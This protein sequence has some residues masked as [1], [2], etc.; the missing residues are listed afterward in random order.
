MQALHPPVVATR[1][2]GRI[3]EHVGID[4]AVPIDA[5]VVRVLPAVVAPPGEPKRAVALPHA[6]GQEDH[7][8]QAIAEGRERQRR[9]PGVAHQAETAGRVASQGH[10]GV[11]V[12]LVVRQAPGL[13]VAPEHH[14]VP[15][16]LARVG[17]APQRR[18]RQCLPGLDLL[19]G[20]A[21][22]LID[23]R[24][25]D[26]GNPRPRGPHPD[27]LRPRP[28][29]TDV[30]DHLDRPGLPPAAVVLPVA[31][32]VIGTRGRDEHLR[33]GLR[34]G[35]RGTGRHPRVGRGLLEIRQDVDDPAAMQPPRTG[36]RKVAPIRG[37]RL[38]GHVEVLRRQGE[39]LEIVAALRA[40]RG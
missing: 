21:G 20:R 24:R 37:H 29:V 28:G 3:L 39:L 26:R 11:E 27:P 30:V 15:G 8:G 14:P 36:G 4:H 10:E 38:V 5:E 35:G 1:P 2:G 6:F 22:R 34:D 13:V 31:R 33:D 17:G 23:R 7:V 12:R 40:P 32:L 25:A 9:L 16:N 18:Q 19:Q